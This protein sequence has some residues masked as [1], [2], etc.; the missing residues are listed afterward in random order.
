MV[1]SNRTAHPGKKPAN[2]HDK[3]A[4][5]VI[6]ESQ[7]VGHIPKI[8]HRLHGILLHKAAL[9]SVQYTIPLGTCKE[10]HYWEKGKGKGLE[11]SCKYIYYYGSTKDTVFIR[12][13]SFIFVILLFPPATK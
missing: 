6:K 11:V 13:P 5:A 1:S 12:N 4:L 10:G 9:L 3:F 2:P 7:I 8:I